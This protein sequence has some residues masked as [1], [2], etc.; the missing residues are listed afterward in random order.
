MK[1]I[2]YK[3]KFVAC[4]DLPIISKKIEPNAKC[5]CGSDKKAKKCCGVETKYYHQKRK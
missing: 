4:N 3:A 1:K 2:T 5:E